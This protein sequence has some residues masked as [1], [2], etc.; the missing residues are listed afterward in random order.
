MPE[1]V[2]CGVDEVGRGP[3]AGPVV[4]AC[5][6]IPDKSLP[7]LAEI[8]DSKKLSKAKR[9]KLAPMILEHCHCGIAELPPTEIDKI[10]ILQATMHAMAMAVKNCP[11]EPDHIYIDGNRVPSGLPCPADAIIKGDDTVLEIACA[12]IIAKVYRDQYMEQIGNEYPHYDWSN[13]AGYG[14][15]KHMDAI[16]KYGVTTH[17]RH[18]FAPVRNA[19]LAA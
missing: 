4:A 1:R 18:S 14:T 8:R 10:N 9:E 6:S 17:H 16:Q 15:K 13:N 2:I 3:L 11:I 12:S 5:V 19:H 7:F